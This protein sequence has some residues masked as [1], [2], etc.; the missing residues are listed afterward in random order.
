MCKNASPCSRANDRQSPVRL[1]HTTA[2][3][4]GAGSGYGAAMA[5]RFA[6]EGARVICVDIAAEAAQQ[7]ARELTDA[8]H[9]ALAVQCD[10]AS[11]DSVRDMVAQVVRQWGGF[12]VLINNAGVSQKPARIAKTSEADIDRLLAVNLKSLYHMAVHALPVLRQSG[13]AC[14]INIAS[15]TALR[16][17]P[18]MTWYNATKAAMVSITQSMAAELA[19]DGIRVNAIA[20]AAGRTPMFAAMF[21]DEIKGGTE[22]VLATIPLGRL[23][24][25][26]DIASAA[27]YLASDDAAFVT[28]I[29]L[30]VDGGR[31]VA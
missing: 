25:P 18:G 4:T 22:R 20:P 2:L 26:S 9:E 5:R 31:L 3:I 30:P 17:R 28:G 19:P 23:C 6:A 15:V 7:I 1:I 24:E 27:V 11:G 10:V 29:V 16:P 14:V 13:G 8:G 12:N 21:G